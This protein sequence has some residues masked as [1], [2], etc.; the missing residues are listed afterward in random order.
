MSIPNPLLVL[1]LWSIGFLFV[2]YLRSNWLVAT[3]L[4]LSL[5]FAFLL[6][7]PNGKTVASW[8]QSLPDL[9]QRVGC[10]RYSLPQTLPWKTPRRPPECI[11]RGLDLS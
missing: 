10:L 9:N 8:N 6:L 2:W 3:S 5:C 1:L 7:S 4:V 11:Y